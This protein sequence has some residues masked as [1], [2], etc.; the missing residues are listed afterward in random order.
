MNIVRGGEMNS[1]P[2]TPTLCRQA[3]ELTNQKWT[4]SGDSRKAIWHI[5][6]ILSWTRPP[7]HQE[8]KMVTKRDWVGWGTEWKPTAT[9]ARVARCV[10]RNGAGRESTAPEP[11]RRAW[12]PLRVP[13]P[14]PL[15][16]PPAREKPGAHPAPALTSRLPGAG[17]LR[18]PTPRGGLRRP[19]S[20]SC[21]GVP[22]AGGVGG[23]ETRL[24]LTCS[25]AS[26][27][28]Q[29]L[30]M[31]LQLPRAGASLIALA[32]L[33]RCQS[34][35][36][37]LGH[38]E[39][40]SGGVCSW[41]A[42]EWGPERA[43]V[44]ARVSS[45]D[46]KEG[47]GISWHP[48]WSPRRAGARGGAQASPLFPSSLFHRVKVIKRC[49]H[50]GKAEVPQPWPAPAVARGPRRRR[51]ARS[52]P[53][54]ARIEAVLQQLPALLHIWFVCF[55]RGV[56]TFPLASRR[57]P[58]SRTHTH[59]PAPSPALPLAPWGK[60]IGRND[61][62]SGKQSLP[63]TS[64]VPRLSQVP[65]LQRGGVAGEVRGSKAGRLGAARRGG[66][67][68]C[69]P[70]PSRRQLP[71]IRCPLFPLLAPP[72]QLLPFRRLGARST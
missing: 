61:S 31:V 49:V 46:R 10:G 3:R 54:T 52:A 4:E 48:N 22:S 35:V 33:P 13:L 51:G 58:L 37:V 30:A 40:K 27:W 17:P 25:P 38:R 12:S 72:S 67:A 62:P 69:R 63:R 16:R 2:E 28:R 34:A 55:E 15:P 68:L 39:P 43:C 32:S 71:R 21:R 19:G 65:G 8:S 44:R 60:A 64:P 6:V 50:R 26:W 1:L 9:L 23:R 56:K 29:H 36:A 57:L 66:S 41:R 70:P 18:P 7:T 20:S 5:P 24:A 47:S 42:C 45:S 53:P 11:P 14:P 59:P